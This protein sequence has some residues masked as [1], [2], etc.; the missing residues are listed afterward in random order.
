MTAEPESNDFRKDR[1]RRVLN[2]LDLFSGCGGLSTGF[3]QVGGFRIA[4]A[5]E[6]DAAAAR[7]YM[8][9]HPGTSVVE[10]DIT[11]E[12]TRQAIID[13]LAGMRCDVVV[14]GVPCQ[15]YTKSKYRDPNDPRG[16]LYEP[17]IEI[18]G[19]LMPTV[20]VIEN[21]P[22]IMTA[23]HPDGSL[24]QHRIAAL[25]RALGYAVA[26]QIL[27]AANFGVPQRRNRTF[28]F[29]WRRGTY[30]RLQQTHDKQ[31]RGGLPRWLTVR[32]AIGD[33]E[34]RGEDAAW[35]HVFADHKPHYLER[36]RSTPV[37]RSA[38]VSYNEGG[39]RNP[40]DL[41]C[42][43]LRGGAWPIHYRNHRVFSPR[44][45]ARIQGFPDDFLFEGNK[46][47]V[48]LQ[49]GNAVPPP[50]AKAVGITVLGML[51]MGSDKRPNPFDTAKHSGR[52]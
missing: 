45:G 2:V 29:A 46:S 9:N 19:R 44:E 20:V 28:I 36:I 4:V 33:L 42:R 6:K 47:E 3:R 51:G 43:T 39:Y 22:D 37:G 15:A 13:A 7:T 12:S 16:R 11:M 40:P 35:S 24:V 48:M 21:V 14:G 26:F 8:L 5:C 30:P 27:N 41:P 18:I 49:I 17:F 38:A 1:C 32:D 25:L 31:G 52:P 10:G 50:L 34:D 23:R